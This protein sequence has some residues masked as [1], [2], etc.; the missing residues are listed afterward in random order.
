MRSP[1]VGSMAAGFTCF[2]PWDL[3]HSYYTC[4][5]PVT[6]ARRDQ[7][8]RTQPTS[9]VPVRSSHHGQ[10]KSATK[11]GV[12]RTFFST[13]SHS[14]LDDASYGAFHRGGAVLGANAELRNSQ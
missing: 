10:V 7:P 8:S 2:W 13:E 12:A 6:V 3:V 14:L 9:G 5:C 11:R 1:T 4:A